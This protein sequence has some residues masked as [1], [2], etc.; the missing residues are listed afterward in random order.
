MSKKLSGTAD[1]FAELFDKDW[2]S[3]KSTIRVR[4]DNMKT[5]DPTYSW[6][7]KVDDPK[8]FSRLQATYVT[9]QP[10]KPIVLSGAAVVL[11]ENTNG[12]NS[13]NVK[14]PSSELSKIPLTIPQRDTGMKVDLSGTIPIL[15][16]AKKLNAAVIM[17]ETPGFNRH[18]M[19]APTLQIAEPPKFMEA[20]GSQCDKKLLNPQQRR[21]IHEFE[22]KKN[23][24]DKL[25]LVAQA[26]RHKTKKQM[27][28]MQYHRGV[29][30]FD[31]SDNTNSEIYGEKARLE[32]TQNEYKQQFELERL[33][34]LSS[35]QSSIH[36]NGNFINPDSVAARV[37]TEK[38][39]QGKGGNYHGL[40]FDETHNRLFFRPA[41]RI[42]FGPR[43][44]HLRDLEL[45]NKNYDIVKHTEIEHWPGR[46]IDRLVDKKL[47]HPSQAAVESQRNLQGSLRPV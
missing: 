25:L 44:Q 16:D 30:M 32:Q 3:A 42:E 20:A 1:K 4:S 10:V 22:K 47:L 41:E 8:T 34:K 45:G 17:T 9:S 18:M 40:S 15:N 31:S 26:E 11:L 13:I 14:Q 35:K 21:Q 39:Y 29:L 43:T 27:S 23:E 7:A 19:Q 12:F 2:K 5:Y 24:A 36:T 6:D 28:G 37:K 46:T 33:S 38:Y